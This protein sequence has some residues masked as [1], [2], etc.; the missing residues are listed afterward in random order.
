MEYLREY[1]QKYETVPDILLVCNAEGQILHISHKGKEILE[2]LSEE[3][4]FGKNLVD[5]FSEKDRPFVQAEILPIA[6]RNG[7]WQGQV[8]VLKKSGEKIPTLQIATVLPSSQKGLSFLLFI[9]GGT[10]ERIRST[11]IIYRAFRQSKNAM[12]L[13]DKD[14]VILAANRQFEVISGFAESELIGKTPKVFQSYPASLEFY[15]EFW[16]TILDGKEFQ[17]SFPNRNRSG[18]YLQWNQII[19]PIQDEEGKI[20]NF[21]MVLSQREVGGPFQLRG[22]SEIAS[23]GTTQPDV[24]RRFEGYDHQSLVRVLREKTKLTKKEADICASIASG[25]DKHQICEE[26]G[27]HSGTL[28]NHLKSIYRK[29]IDLE[30][31]IP[32]PERDKLQK[33]TIY[34]FR[35]AGN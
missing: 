15:N 16:E 26:L 29:T 6:L 35:L 8:Y 17:G 30:K 31:E 21:L 18:R 27:I 13:T 1:D 9:K 10:S 5:L 24:L 22:S 12:F 4:L 32:G 23:K 33:L 25:K 34:L 2:F 11:D 20:T 28:K 7:E 19:S 14:G 3:L